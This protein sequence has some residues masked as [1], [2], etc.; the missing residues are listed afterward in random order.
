MTPTLRF[1][2]L[3]SLLICA[4]LSIFANDAVIAKARAYL[5]SDSA[6]DAVRSLHFTGQLTMEESGQPKSAPV[7]MEII[8]SQADR[9]LIV[10][11]DPAKIETTA[12]DGYDGWQRIEDPIAPQQW[13]VTLLGAE[14]IRRLRANT[15]ENLAFYRG[16]AARGARIEDLGRTQMD[17]VNCQK[18]AFIHAPNIVFI[19]Y[20]EPETGRLVLTETESG[21]AIREEGEIKVGGVRFP[22]T[23]VTTTQST[24]GKMRS[25]RVDFASVKINESLDEARFAIPSLNP[26]R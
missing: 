6:L 12:L 24:D 15:F 11:R 18:V 25:I 3:L 14:Q 1:F 20:F 2:A 4:P 16:H 26:S 5:G 17:G 21:T 7:D 22:K 13:S 8:F 9:Q 19:R 10:V 23:I